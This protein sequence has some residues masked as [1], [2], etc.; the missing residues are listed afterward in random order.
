M[1]I[2]TILT[3]PAIQRKA[4]S[5]DEARRK[6]LRARGF[7]HERGGYH[8][9]VLHRYA[10]R[11]PIAQSQGQTLEFLTEPDQYFPENNN[12]NN[13]NDNVN[14]GDDIDDIEGISGLRRDAGNGAAGLRIDSAMRT[15][16]QNQSQNQID[17]AVSNETPSTIHHEMGR[18]QR[19]SDVF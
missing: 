18:G 13:N 1:M 17:S 5:R 14:S 9:K 7:H 19:A 12:K 10:S 2:Y 6:D 11:D 8:D 4:A 16:N 3:P 15:Q